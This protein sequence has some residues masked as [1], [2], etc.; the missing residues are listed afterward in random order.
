MRSTRFVAKFPGTCAGCLE[1]FEPGAWV[2]FDDDDLVH[3]TC[4][5]ITE[6]PKRPVC[7][8]CWQEITPSGACGC[9]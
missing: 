1:R 6:E 8:I 9:G 2:V 4:P 3:E 7:S 5:E